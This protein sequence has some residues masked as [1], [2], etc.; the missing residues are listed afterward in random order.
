M[1]KTGIIYDERMCQHEQ[2]DHPE[3]PE[4]IRSIYSLMQSRNLFKY[5][6]LV[7]I[8]EATDEEILGVHDKTHL[9]YMKALQTM[10]PRQL[11]Q[12]EKAY[13]SVYF[14]SHSYQCARLSAGGVVELCENVIKHNVKNGVAIVRPPGHHAEH[15]VAMGFC[16]FNN[17]AVA[18]KTLINRHGLQRIAIIDWD[19]HHGNA[20]QHMFQSDP[21]ILF[22]SIHRYDNGRFYPC[23]TDASPG[24]VGTNAGVGKNVNIAWNIPKNAQSTVGDAEYIYAFNNVICPMLKE[25]DPQFVI[26]SAGF[27]CAHGDPLGELDVTPAGFNYLTRKLM[28]YANGNIVIALEGGYN[29]QAISESMTACLQALVGLPPLRL[30]VNPTISPIAINAVEQTLAA[31]KPYWNF[32]TNNKN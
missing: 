32:L 22:I 1:E 15:S 3:Q 28:Q 16:L 13:N 27:D 4:R 9:E 24:V 2:D 19:V 12:M 8:R 6:K 25:Y 17:V 14:N 20:T 5:C 21:R 26:V 10:K 29:L 7:P 11:L 23:S 30:A 31:H 18:A